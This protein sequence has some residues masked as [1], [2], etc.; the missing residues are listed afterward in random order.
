M[1]TKTEGPYPARLTSED[2]WLRDAYHF[3]VLRNASGNAT[4]HIVRVPHQSFG[5]AAPTEILKKSIGETTTVHHFLSFELL[6]N[7]K[8]PDKASTELQKRSSNSFYPTSHETVDAYGGNIVP[9]APKVAF[10]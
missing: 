9:L 10:V 4:Q 2:L 1:R 6:K 8:D 5:F 7:L 3:L